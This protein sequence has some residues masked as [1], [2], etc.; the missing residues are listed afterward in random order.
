MQSYIEAQ[1]QK[2]FSIKPGNEDVPIP[3][4]HAHRALV[5]YYKDMR[6]FI[7]IESLE[8]KQLA[9]RFHGSTFLPI[10]PP[11]CLSCEEKKTWLSQLHRR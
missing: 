8:N 6:D 5:H 10:V 3:E 4:Q 11:S 7:V 9:H 2:Y 1:K